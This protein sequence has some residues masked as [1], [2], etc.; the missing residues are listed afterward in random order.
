MHAGPDEVVGFD[1][2]A[3]ESWLPTVAPD[4]RPVTPPLEWRRLPGGHSNLTYQLTDAA[5][6]EMV[7]RRPPR[8]ELL[9]KAHDMWREYR[10]IKGLWPTAVPVAEPI[11][12]CDDP[13]IAETHFYVMG[14]ADG[15][16]LYT[17]TGTAEYLDEAARR[18]AGE[19]FVDTLAALHSLDPADI[20]LAEL[21]RPD[22]YVARQL[23]TWYGSWTASVAIAGHDDARMHEL[24]ELLVGQIPEQGPGRIVHGDFGPHN[25]LFAADG[26]LRAV[27][28]WELATLGDPLAD[29]AYS[30]NAWVEPG[31]PGVYGTDA[32]TVLPGFPRRAELVARYAAATG[33]DVATLN[34]GMA[35]Y[36]AFNYF[37]TAGILIGVYAR[38]VGGQKS[39]DDVDLPMMLGRVTASVDMAWDAGAGL[40]G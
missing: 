5:G 38:Y 15:R 14:K 24:H 21:G 31:D 40:R 7:I 30:L 36:R 11:A 1:P 2:A 12:Y 8:G 18:H 26:E 9:P 32:P 4:D 33:R 27:L 28:D 29:F 19:Q 25:S 10:I 34:G 13:A 22:Q 17:G 39:A 23:K 3:I 35:Y 16:A 20:G 37:K 6:R